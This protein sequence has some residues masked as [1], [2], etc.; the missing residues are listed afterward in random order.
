M[1][2]NE[3]RK[4][5]AKWVCFHTFLKSH[6]SMQD[7][8]PVLASLTLVPNLQTF[9]QHSISTGHRWAPEARSSRLI[10][11]IVHP[12]LLIC[13]QFLLCRFIKLHPSTFGGRTI[14]PWKTG[15]FET[16]HIARSNSN[17]L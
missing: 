13:N 4:S 9:L 14:V 1:Y 5:I 17:S 10:T 2:E 3:A 11:I 15:I 16:N 6:P 12:P 8:K 7:N